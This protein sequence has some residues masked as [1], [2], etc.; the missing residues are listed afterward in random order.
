MLSK[1][2]ILSSALNYT[3]IT[4]LQGLRQKKQNTVLTIVTYHRIIDPDKIDSAN[5]E[6]VSAT[7][8]EFEKQMKFVSEHFTPID[9]F[10]LKE[11]VEK[12]KAVPQN[13][14]IIS[15][16]D[17]YRDNYDNAFPVLKKFN[18]KGVIFLATGFIGTDKTFWWD[19][20]SSIILETSKKQICIPSISEKFLKLS[21]KS[22]V[23]YRRQFIEELLNKIKT[24]PESKKNGIINEL[25]EVCGNIKNSQSVMLDWNMA[26][27][28]QKNGVE[29]GAHTV[30]HPVLSQ[31]KHDDIRR[32]I[33]L[34]G[35]EIREKTGIK[36]V[37]FCYPVGK[38]TSFNE[39]IAEEVKTQGFSFAVTLIHGTNYISDISPFHLKRVN[40]NYLDTF[41]EYKA[42]LLFP[43]IIKY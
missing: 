14:I 39:I 37:S 26:L 34:S 21:E 25:R 6:V 20:I 36:P 2:K 31:I 13:P 33:A 15:F 7:P 11:I 1:R 16:D 3:G 17:G 12:K 23:K 5:R 9:F 28:M 24:M 30:N 18:L 10:D 42:K 38:K 40:I 29:L 43:S 19:E 4:F 22:D 27:E 35:F 8:K 32:E 41:A